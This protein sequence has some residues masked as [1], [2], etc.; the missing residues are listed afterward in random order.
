MDT[1]SI[2]LGKEKTDTGT[3]NKPQNKPLLTM[4]VMEFSVFN[5]I[6]YERRNR[7][8]RHKLQDFLE[9]RR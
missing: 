9:S 5:D 4:V 6:Q 8:S 1:E 7:Q 2:S 3:E